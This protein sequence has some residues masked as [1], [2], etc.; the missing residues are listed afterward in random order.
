MANTTENKPI[1][2]KLE[3]A[4]AYRDAI[5]QAISQAEHTIRIFDFNLENCGYN[6]LRRYDLLRTFLLANRNN[7][8]EIILHDTD[9]LVR[10]CPRL[11]NLGGQF[12]HAISVYQ[13]TSQV[14]DLYDPFIIIDQTHFVHR[15]HYDHPRA[16][17]VF[18]DLAGAHE[19]EERFDA[20][21]EASTPFSLGA[22]LGL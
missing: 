9:Y 19:F 7:R 6:S 22:P 18:N 10:F 5:D 11:L 16:A 2:L 14:K 20:I 3:S 1:F 4:E 15:F 21:R 12:A 17:L 13:T 8:L